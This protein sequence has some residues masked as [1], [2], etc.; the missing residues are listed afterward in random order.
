MHLLVELSGSV[1][2]TAVV[3]N[4]YLVSRDEANGPPIMIFDFDHGG[5]A[6]KVRGAVVEFSGKQGALEFEALGTQSKN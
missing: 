3:L 5:K 6:G 1:G 4:I 2:P